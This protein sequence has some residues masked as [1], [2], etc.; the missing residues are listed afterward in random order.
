MKFD[1]KFMDL[2]A[3]ISVFGERYG[4]MANGEGDYE[5]Q[6][7]DG[8]IIID[9]RTGGGSLSNPIPFVGTDGGYYDL[10]PDGTV[11]PKG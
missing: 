4:I 3:S 6:A 2:D 7:S 11:I 9:P 5:V 8:E 1:P 10:M